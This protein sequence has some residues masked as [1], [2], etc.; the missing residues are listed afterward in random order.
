M[1]WS[2][3][4]DMF[5][6]ASSA[7]SG[8]SIGGGGGSFGAALSVN[9]HFGSSPRSCLGAFIDAIACQG[10]S[11]GCMMLPRIREPL[12]R[13]PPSERMLAQVHAQG[14]I[15]LE[16]RVIEELIGRRFVGEDG[17]GLSV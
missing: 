12:R 16:L 5:S 11:N 7:E 2:R 15:G 9:R 6:A 17:M 1:I 3:I 8:D 10:C 4:H 14:A 13:H